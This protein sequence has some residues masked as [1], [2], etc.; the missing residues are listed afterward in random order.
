M[1]SAGMS[2]SSVLLNS[3]WAASLIAS[4]SNS[5]VRSAPA[6]ALATALPLDVTIV[7]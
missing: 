1:P 5:N 6:A 7:V 2:G 4:F 3:I